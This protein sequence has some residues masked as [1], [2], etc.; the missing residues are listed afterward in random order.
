LICIKDKSI[1]SIGAEI[2]TNVAVRWANQIRPP[3]EPFLC[4]LDVAALR[5]A[6]SHDIA[7]AS[8]LKPAAG[9]LR[10]GVDVA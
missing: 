4:V 2:S 9:S 8:G 1:T 10:R 3:V 6:L 5:T 7:G